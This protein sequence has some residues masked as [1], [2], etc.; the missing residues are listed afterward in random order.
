MLT[1]YLPTYPT[2]SDISCA[3][4]L[5]QFAAAL[6]GYISRYGLNE[7]DVAKVQSDAL[8]FIIWLNHRIC[9]ATLAIQQ[10]YPTND[11]QQEDEL[12]ESTVRLLLF[13]KA[14]KL[15]QV[16]RTHHKYSIIDGIN[17]ELSLSPD[18][19]VFT[20]LPAPQF[21][22][23]G[24]QMLDDNVAVA[25]RWVTYP[26]AVIDLEICRDSHTWHPSQLLVGNCYADIYPKP[27]T[28]LMQWQYRARYRR[29]D[30]P[31]GPWS[32]VATVELSQILVT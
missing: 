31:I 12:T 16:I 7:I 17:L 4:W 9:Y 11:M 2:T 20:T 3:V 19:P 13:E 8:E 21:C 28:N 5:R 30:W 29:P 24:C 10:L 25:L 14:A 18:Y 1:K 32:Q 22:I 6:P 27:T 15:V 23:V 26:E